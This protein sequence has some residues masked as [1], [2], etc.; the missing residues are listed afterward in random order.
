LSLIVTGHAVSLGVARAVK[1]AQDLNRKAALT[2]IETASIEAAGEVRSRLLDKTLRTALPALNL[3]AA[4]GGNLTDSQ[5]REALLLEA[6]LR[7]EIRGEALLN[8]SMRFAIK[9]ARERGVE[10]LV[11]DEGGLEGLG[12]EEREQ[13]LTRA[14]ASFSSVNA[15][16]LTL[17]S[18]Q[19]EDWRI[20]VAAVRPGTSAPDLW[21]KLS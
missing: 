11:L 13:L 8:D 6:A 4:L 21:L 5:K 9:A 7:D 19:G 18:P 14:S 15:G 2:A 12:L 1:N 10:V 20:T 17:R 3:I 16:R